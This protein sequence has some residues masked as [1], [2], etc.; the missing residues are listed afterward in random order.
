MTKSVVTAQ[1]AALR[2]WLVQAR[3]GAG[4]SQAEFARRLSRPQALVSKYES[5]ERRID[6]VELL[7]IAEAIGTETVGCIQ[8][9][10]R[11]SRTSKR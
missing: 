3:R 4:L 9:L 2:R 7:A 6:V 10:V 11:A 1:Y 5:G 8:V